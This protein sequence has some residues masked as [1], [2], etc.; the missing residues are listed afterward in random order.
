M[1]APVLSFVTRSEVMTMAWEYRRKNLRDRARLQ[2]SVDAGRG[3][4]AKRELEAWRPMS[5]SEALK[6]AW[7][8]ARNRAE[9]RAI[10]QA[11]G[12]AV[13]RLREI[14]SQITEL[15]GRTRWQSHYAAMA[16]LRTQQAAAFEAVRASI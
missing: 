2:W 12:P 11:Q 16:D 7:E 5:M 4:D 8:A 1:K 6:S 15:D 14:E 10:D 13:D 9:L 3:P